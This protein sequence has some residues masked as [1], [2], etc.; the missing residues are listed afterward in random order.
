MLS[1][2]TE[3]CHLFLTPKLF[4]HCPNIHTMHCIVVATCKLVNA[5]LCPD[6]HESKFHIAQSQV[7]YLNLS[8]EDVPQFYDDLT[9]SS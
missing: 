6:K 8:G 2:S 4:T 3:Y 5:H 7:L 9:T 1:I